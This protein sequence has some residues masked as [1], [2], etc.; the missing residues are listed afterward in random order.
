MRFQEFAGTTAV[1]DPTEELFPI[2]TD[3]LSEGI[4]MAAKRKRQEEGDEDEEEKEKEEEAEP[5]AEP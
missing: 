2:W 4:L 3:D 5:A 1:F